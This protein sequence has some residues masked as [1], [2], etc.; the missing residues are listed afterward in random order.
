MVKLKFGLNLLEILE[1][2][3]IE[4]IEYTYIIGTRFQRSKFPTSGK[5]FRI[6]NFIVH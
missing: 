6:G 4:N 1:N 5:K 3:N 2:L